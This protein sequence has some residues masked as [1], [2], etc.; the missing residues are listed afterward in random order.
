M[1]KKEHD[2]I[3]VARNRNIIFDLLHSYNFDFISRGY[4]STNIFG[5]FFYLIKADFQLYTVARKLN[6]DLF[7]SFGSMYAAHTAKLLKKPHISFDD[8]EHAKL[9]HLIYM[10]FTNIICVPSC[11]KKYLGEKQ[12][13]FN[14]YMELCYLHPNYFKPDHNILNMLRVEKGEKYVIMRFVS[15]EASHDIGHKGISLGNKIN[16]VKEFSKYAKVFISS[17]VPLVDE[18]KEYQIR[19][20]P[21]KMHDA[22]YYAT[23][24]YGEGATMASECAVLG[25]P[26]IFLNNNRLGLTDEEEKRYGLVFNFT[27]SLPDQERSIRKGVELLQTPNLKLEWEKRRNNMLSEKIDVTSFMVWFIEDYP[28]S[29]KVMKEN[30]DFQYSFM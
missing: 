23:L 20:P 9:A 11:F 7:L 29:V 4:G 28:E 12:L 22:L 13:I 24:L 10:P 14:G 15:W 26:A 17:E 21:E 3:I 8:T 2:F 25:T 30:P 19:I 1:K 5:K 18:L 6:P 27:E 16:A